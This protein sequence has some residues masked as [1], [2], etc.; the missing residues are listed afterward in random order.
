MPEAHFVMIP[1]VNTGFS[2]QPTTPVRDLDPSRGQRP[3]WRSLASAQ[4]Q[5]HRGSALA[6]GQAFGGLGPV[7]NLDGAGVSNT[8]ASGVDGSW[9]SGPAIASKTD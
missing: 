2:E 4:M 5:D 9:V 6:T 7:D 1:L 3:Y 8:Y